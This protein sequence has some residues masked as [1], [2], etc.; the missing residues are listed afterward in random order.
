MNR[1]LINVVLVFHNKD[2]SKKNNLKDQLDP[3]RIDDIRL[4]L[5]SIPL[6]NKSDFK[7]IHESEIIC[8]LITPS[9]ISY[10]TDPDDKIKN[11]LI[12]KIENQ[13]KKG[14]KLIPIL[15][16]ACLWEKPQ[17][18]R[19]L[20]PLPKNIKFVDDKNAWGNHDEALCEI[21]KEI[22]NVISEIR[23][24][25]EV[26][27]EY[28]NRLFLFIKNNKSSE[29]ISALRREYH[30]TDR[31]AETIEKEVR[32]V[33]SKQRIPKYIQNVYDYPF[34]EKVSVWFN[35]LQKQGGLLLIAIP[36]IIF[37][38]LAASLGNHK[39]ISSNTESQSCLSSNSL[40]RSNSHQALESHGWIWIGIYKGSRDAFDYNPNLQTEEKKPTI[41]SSCAPSPGQTV[42]LVD[43]VNLRSEPDPSSK[44]LDQI[45]AGNKVAIKRIDLY[46]VSPSW[47]EVWAE[48]HRYDDV[49]K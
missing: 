27:Q 23:D 33:I 28:K 18:F 45:K 12:I 35:R 15:Y 40:P 43:T 5:I 21:A 37:V 32:D 49:A 42:T 9:I 19:D 38:G 26:C 31:D 4:S 36:I 3:L 30:I 2:D 20:Q 47:Y 10:L 44:K 8:F 1:Q 22:D 17:I 11:E 16:T 39:S 46:E 7:E 29:E 34:Y 13:R 6:L 14:L 25:R 24:Y 48:I 41:N